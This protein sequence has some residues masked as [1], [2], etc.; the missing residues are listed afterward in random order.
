[1]HVKYILNQNSKNP[2]RKLHLLSFLKMLKVWFFSGITFIKKHGLARK[3]WV[4]SIYIL[5]QIKPLTMTLPTFIQ[6]ALER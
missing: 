3:L 1:M 5:W 2:L 4:S 6:A